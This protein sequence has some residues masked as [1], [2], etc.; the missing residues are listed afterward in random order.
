MS[1]KPNVTVIFQ[2]AKP[3]P[4]GCAEVAITVLAA[5]G[6]VAILWGWGP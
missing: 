4:P 2:D 6:L 1:D 3:A 5:V